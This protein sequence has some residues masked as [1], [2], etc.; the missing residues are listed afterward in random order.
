[1]PPSRWDAV[2]G[3]A[4]SRYVNDAITFERSIFRENAIFKMLPSLHR[5][6]RYLQ[7]DAQL[8][9]VAGF[10]VPDTPTHTHRPSTVTFAHARRGL[11]TIV[12][13]YYIIEAQYVAIQAYT[14]YMD[15]TGNIN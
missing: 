7:L 9:I 4:A 10:V 14:V 11:I 12:N 13:S 15:E 5:S 2:K 6:R 1:M 3:S 8:R